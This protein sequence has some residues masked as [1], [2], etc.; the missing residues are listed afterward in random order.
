MYSMVGLLFSRTNVAIRRKN[1]LQNLVEVRI[2][3][4]LKLGTVLNYY[5]D[6][7]NFV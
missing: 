1:Q 2:K 3:N 5:Y 7:Y 4:I 6:N